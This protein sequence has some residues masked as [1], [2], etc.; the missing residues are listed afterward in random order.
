METTRSSIKLESCDKLLVDAP[1][2][3]ASTPKI[4]ASTP[5]IIASTPKIQ[6]QFRNAI[7]LCYSSLEIRNIIFEIKL[8]IQNFWN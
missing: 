1:K 6:G 7:L 2:I 3:I 5:K 4:I 8:K